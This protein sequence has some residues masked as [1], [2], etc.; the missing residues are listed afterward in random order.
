MAV[1]TDRLLREAQAAMTAG[2]DD[3]ALELLRRA[4]AQDAT[5]PAPSFHLGNL[6]ALRGEM[7]AAIAAYERALQRAPTHP[8]LLVNLGI[9]RDQNGDSAEAERCYRE[10]LRRQPA[11]IA[12]L[13]NL[14]LSLFRRDEFAAALEFYDRLLAAMPQ[15]GPEVWNNRGICQRQL[16]DRAA[17]EQSFRRA[18]ALEPASAEICANLGFLLSEARR[19]DAAGPLL[20]KASQLDPERLLV[21]AQSLDVDLQF[22]DWRDFERRCD[23]IVAAVAS[24]AERPRQSVPPYLLLAICDDPSLQLVAAK[25]WAWPQPQAAHARAVL[26]QR[27]AEDRLRIGFVSSAFHDHPVPRLLVELLERIDRSRFEVYAYSLGR[28]AADA[29]RER[30]QRA[31]AALVE[32]GHQS[33]AAMVD[34]IRA[35]GIDILFDL[36]GHTGQARPDLFAARPA[37]VQVNYLGYAGTLGADYYDFVITDAYTT[38]AGAEGDFVERCCRIGECYV[39]TDT[40][41]PIEPPPTRAHYSLPD[42]ALI[43]MTQAAPYKILPAVFDIWM[44]LL[45]S[46]PDALLWLRPLDVTAQTNLRAEADRR[47]V[48]ARR[49]VFA[50]SEPVPRYLAR[51]ALGDLYLDTHP[52]GSHTTVN[53]ALLTGLP[54]LTIAGRS[55]AARASAAQ[56]RAAG[57]PELVAASSAEYEAIARSLAHDRDRLRTLTGRLREEGRASALFDMERYARAFEAGIERMWADAPAGGG[58]ATGAAQQGGRA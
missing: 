55:M 14:A 54:V 12:A 46:R 34:R 51:Y 49:L 35:D 41:Q 6:L 58:A 53:D 38:P 5:N 56:V 9:A 31:V 39:P 50:P 10:V 47:G 19:Y 21:T 18:L 57:L 42:D 13:G 7:A 1:T 15:A 30:I 16:G 44:R 8:D 17:A 32:L 20:R 33:T 23:A 3:D 52:F 29:L 36:T 40:R 4:A 11:H 43:L 22:A 2:R 24:F 26:R 27:G 45:R 48:A 37:P 28:G 25:R